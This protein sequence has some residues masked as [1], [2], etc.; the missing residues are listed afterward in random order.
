[1]RSITGHYEKNYKAV[2]FSHQVPGS[3]DELDSKQFA[4]IIQVL[5]YNKADEHT[6]AVSLLALLFGKDG[7]H[8]LDNLPDEDRYSLVP[9][10]NFIRDVKPPVYNPF[11]NLKI[12]KRWCAAPAQDL[13]NMSFGEWCFA[14]QF[15]TYYKLTN[16]SIWVNK[17]IACLYRPA[18]LSQDKESP[19][20]TGDVREAFNENLIDSRAKRIASIPEHFRLGVLA[21]FTLAV[22]T[23]MEARPLV[24]P[25]NEIDQQETIEDPEQ[26]PEID[27]RT[28]LTVFRE[29]LGP[30]WGTTNRLKHTNAMFVLDAL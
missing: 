13:S 14:F 18:D 8:I 2:K 12:H 16:D 10:T 29:L 15:Y 26:T 27:S 23:V 9:L 25:V 30:K 11:P 6:I 1:M 24:F 28:W 20:Y 7:W 19:E 21:W 3:W 4:R 22:Q 5:H 17:L